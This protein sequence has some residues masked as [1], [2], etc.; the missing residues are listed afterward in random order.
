M[1][2][3]WRWG[4]ALLLGLGL[5][6]AIGRLAG[7]QLPA[8]VARVESFGAWGPL[9][10][11]ALYVVGSVALVPG[12]ILTLTSGALFGLARGTLYAWV[13]A[14]LGATAAFLISRYVA[15]DRVARRLEGDDR[16]RRIDAA[17]EREGRRVV[18]LLRLSP[19]FPFALLNYAL[20]LT[21]VRLVDYVVGF[22]GMLPGT[23]LYVYQGVLVG[24]VAAL[25][26][27]AVERGAAYYLVLIL[28]LAATVAVTV[29]VTRLARRA[30][31]EETPDGVVTR[32]G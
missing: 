5:V 10:L 2:G 17:I 8:L 30:L 1:K 31:H 25:G 16:L 24:E 6:L 14:S 28:G 27:G 22:L 15:R 7:D 20:G 4:A 11:I 29:L 26:A 32:A 19:V 9:A 12:S 21:R 13:G 3:W 23:L 18:F